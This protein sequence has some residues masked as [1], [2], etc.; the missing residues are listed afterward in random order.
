MSEVA[1]EVFQVDSWLPDYKQTC[2][3]GNS[4][5]VTAEKNGEVVYD[6]GMCGVCIWGSS[7]CLDPGEWN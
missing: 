2:D 4:P 6:H 5:T 3:C 1:A 7:A